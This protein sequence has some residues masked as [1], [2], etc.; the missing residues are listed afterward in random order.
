MTQ[1]TL[2][3][4]ENRVWRFRVEGHAGYASHGEDVVCASISVL[5]INTINAIEKF[6]EEPIKELEVNQ[7]KG[8][9]DIAFPN[10]KIGKYEEEAELLIKSMLLGLMTIQEMYGEKYIQIQKK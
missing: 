3:C 2:Y 9:I 5:V 4:K 10:R 7:Q 8:I 1:I 6:T